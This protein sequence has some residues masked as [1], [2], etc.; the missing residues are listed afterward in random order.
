MA[1]SPRM[2]NAMTLFSSTDCV[3]CHRVR[4]VLAHRARLRP[5]DVDRLIAREQ[6]LVDQGHAKL[7]SF[8]RTGD[9]LHGCHRAQPISGR[10]RRAATRRRGQTSLVTA[11]TIEAIR[12]TTSTT[13]MY[14]QVGGIVG[15]RRG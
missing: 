9:A 3:L 7:G 15:S 2:R 4:L 12:Q 11:I 13:I 10:D 1:A 8:D 6:V 5:L 14:F